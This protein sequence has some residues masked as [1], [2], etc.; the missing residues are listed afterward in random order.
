MTMISKE[1]LRSVKKCV[2]H[3]PITQHKIYREDHRASA[4]DAN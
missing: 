4:F 1:K 2:L 3:L